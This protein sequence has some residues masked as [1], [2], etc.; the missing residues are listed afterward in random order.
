MI[1]IGLSFS[2]YHSIPTHNQAIPY[3]DVTSA[4]LFPVSFCDLGVMS[5]VQMPSCPLG[6]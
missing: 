2:S 1:L 4:I 5:S 3:L 6:R